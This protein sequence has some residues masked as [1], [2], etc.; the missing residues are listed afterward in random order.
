M[1]PFDRAGEI[2]H[3]DG[4]RDGVAAAVHDGSIAEQIVDRRRDA[5]KIKSVPDVLTVVSEAS[6]NNSPK[7]ESP[8][9]SVPVKTWTWYWRA[10]SSTEPLGVSHSTMPSF[11]PSP[12]W[13][14]L[15][16]PGLFSP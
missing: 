6:A 10:P 5:G 3:I 8:A 12:N 15:L 14:M 2:A 4:Q 16:C 7:L 13:T 1:S 9:L 11:V